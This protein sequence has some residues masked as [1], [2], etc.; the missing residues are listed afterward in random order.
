MAMF[1]LICFLFLVLVSWEL[2]LRS[3]CKPAGIVVVGRRWRG[4][5]RKSS[6]SSYLVKNAAFVFVLAIHRALLGW[7]LKKPPVII[8]MS[9]L[10]S[11][12]QDCS[13]PSGTATAQAFERSTKPWLI[14]QLKVDCNIAEASS[15]FQNIYHRTQQGQQDDSVEPSS[16]SSIKHLSSLFFSLFFAYCCRRARRGGAL[17]SEMA[18]NVQKVTLV[19]Y[20]DFGSSWHLFWELA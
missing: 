17:C 19:G 15:L 3:H 11:F 5:K 18:E 4:G 20:I 2:C 13:N 7:W 9:K 6:L 14:H 10:P 16:L 12:A 1:L 8:C